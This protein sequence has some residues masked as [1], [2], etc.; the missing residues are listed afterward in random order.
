MWEAIRWYCKN[1]YSIFCFGRTAPENRGLLQFKS[2]WGTRQEI[3]KYYKYDLRKEAYINDHSEISYFSRKVFNKM[4]VPLLRMIGTLL[5][6]H[7]A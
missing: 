7:V 4:P 5:Y 3:L 2:G 6:K 1:G